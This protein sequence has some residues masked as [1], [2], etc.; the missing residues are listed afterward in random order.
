M[1]HPHGETCGRQKEITRRALAEVVRERIAARRLRQTTVAQR[2]G[3]SRSFLR[4]ILLAQKGCTLFV[5]LQLSG[6]LGVDSPC[7]LLRE[8][9]KRRDALRGLR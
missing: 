5:F 1:M 3:I 2:A 4:S 7:D 9:L 8:V 6:E